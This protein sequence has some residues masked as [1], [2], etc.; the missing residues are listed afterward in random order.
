M[1]LVAKSD[2]MLLDPARQLNS[3]LLIVEPNSIGLAA[4]PDPATLFD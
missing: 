4:K 1:S 3:R 2:P